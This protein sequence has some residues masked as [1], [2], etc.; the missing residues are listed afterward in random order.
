MMTSL[1]M[2]EAAMATF[3][4]PINLS[5]HVW[6]TLFITFL[7]AS[8][9]FRAKTTI[10][11]ISTTMTNKS[12]AEQSI[13][14]IKMDTTR[15]CGHDMGCL[16]GKYMTGF[17]TKRFQAF[18]GIPY[19]LPPVGELRFA[20]PKVFPRWWDILDATKPKQDCVQKNYILPN[21]VVQGIE[22]CLYLNVYRPLTSAQQPLPVMVY[23]HGGGW[24]SGS[25][26]PLLQGPEYFMDTKE[27]ILV[28]IAY[29]LGPFGFLS[30]DDANM[31]GNLGLK[32]Q[33]LALR[34]IKRNI[35]AFGGDPAMVTIFGQSAGAVSAHLHMLSKQSEGLFDSIITMSGTANVPF[36]ITDH[37]L[38]QTRTMAK[39]CNISNADEMSTVELARALRAVN[40]IELLEAGDSLKY[41]NVDPMTNFRPIVEK[42]ADKDAFLTQHPVQLLA[43]GTY[44]PVPWL[45]GMVPGEGAVRVLSILAN[46]TLKQQFNDNFHELLEKLLEFPESFNTAQLVAKTQHVIDEYFDGQAEINNATA[47]G[48]LECINDRA[49]H[50]PYY[51]AIDAYVRTVD[52]QKYPIYLYKFNYSGPNSFANIYTGGVSIGDFGVMHCDDLIYSFRAPV[53][54]PDFQKLSVDASVVAQFVGTFVHF[55]KYGK[56]QNAD[57]LRS[58]NETTFDA[59]SEAICDYQE[60]RNAGSNAFKIFTNNEFNVRRAKLWNKI[61]EIDDGSKIFA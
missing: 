46:Q 23:I 32:D 38:Q 15:V 37:P 57:T 28:T 59:K 27:V 7:L 6:Q 24:F 2:A 18:L 21:P 30:T 60:F 42:H 26:S 13:D 29:R 48:F 5:S 47:R 31:P 56:P 52:T 8:L 53:L 19:A 54:F 22:D 4:S 20:N 11:T 50:Q 17:Q 14:M 41:W 55:A 45:A 43:K 9:C 12:C 10:T 49:F 1:T 40:A 35:A 36:A 61:L 44:K 33:N 58:C 39:L 34:W 51:N 16:Q 25:A 3:L